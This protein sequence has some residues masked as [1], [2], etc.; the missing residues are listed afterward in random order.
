MEAF[1]WSMAENLPQIAE[2]H[3]AVLIDAV[4]SRTGAQGFSPITAFRAIAPAI[5]RRISGG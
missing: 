5:R 4:N 2:N 3:D 1:N